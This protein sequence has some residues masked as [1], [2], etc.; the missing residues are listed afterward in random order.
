ML[1]FNIKNTEKTGFKNGNSYDF[2][3]PCTSHETCSPYEVYFQT[4]VYFIELWGAQGGNRTDFGVSGGKGAF[5]SG[6]LTIRRSKRLYLYIGASGIHASDRSIFGGGGKGTNSPDH[7]TYGGSGGG[8]TDLRL[9]YDDL[10]SRIA[11]AAGGAGSL[12][13]ISNVPGGDAGGITGFDGAYGN[14][15]SG[16]T[17]ALVGCGGLQN[18][19][20]PSSCNS[21]KFGIGSDSGYN[22]GSGGGGGYYGGG[23]GRA[24]SCSISSGGGGSSYISG[25]PECVK[26]PSYILRNSIIHSGRDSFHLPSG[27]LSTGNTGNGYARITFCG[28]SAFNTCKRFIHSL[29]YNTLF[30]S[31]I[32]RT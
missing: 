14:C 17:T 26:N 7:K 18:S 11:V 22:H 15:Q 30:I 21:G 25:H 13:Y 6:Y 9:K 19:S 8:A 29:F 4:G 27:D 1:S 10:S 23:N 20:F 24:G 31:I 28:N 12:Y 16:Y 5:V 32:I 3:Y 2:P